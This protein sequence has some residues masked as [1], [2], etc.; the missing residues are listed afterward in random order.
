MKGSMSKKLV[1]IKEVQFIWNQSRDREREKEDENASH[2]C[3]DTLRLTQIAAY[4]W[5]STAL[6]AIKK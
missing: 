3:T 4:L 2:N 6:G 1:A 5:I